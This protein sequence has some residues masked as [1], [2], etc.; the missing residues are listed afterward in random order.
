MPANRN[1]CLD[2]LSPKKTNEYLSTVAHLRQT[3]ALRM[4]SQ[5]TEVRVT[6]TKPGLKRRASVQ[7]TDEGRA[8]ERL[9]AQAEPS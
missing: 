9:D 3:R 8:R 1:S 2:E 7:R 5:Q 6:T 4:F